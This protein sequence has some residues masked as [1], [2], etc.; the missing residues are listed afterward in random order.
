MNTFLRQLRFLFFASGRFDKI[1]PP[2][3]PGI[4]YQ[5]TQ[6]KG[7]GVFA[8]IPFKKQEL[9]ERSPVIVI[10][11]DQGGLVKDTVLGNYFFDWDDDNAIALG[12]GSLFNHSYHPNAGYIYVPKEQVIDFFAL[13][14]IQPGEEITINYNGDPGGQL[15]TWFEVLD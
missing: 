5:K 11:Q 8:L 13:D 15:D 9:I 1:I 7:R 2:A 3:N 6:N 10:P 4:C 14:E 12:Y